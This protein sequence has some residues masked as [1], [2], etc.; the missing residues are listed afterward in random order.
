MSEPRGNRTRRPRRNQGGERALLTLV[1]LALFPVGA[2]AGSRAVWI[3]EPETYRMLEDRRFTRQV[4]EFLR[5]RSVD[6]VFLYADEFQGRN[7]I[8]QRPGLYRGLIRDLRRGGVAPHALLGSAYLRTQE[9]ILPEKREAALAMVRRVLE[10]NAA[11]ASEERFAGLQLDIEPHLLD[12]WDRDRDALLGL[13][14]ARSAE[15]T[16]MARESGRDFV[17]SAA[18]PFWLDGIEIDW[19]GRGARVSDHVQ[20]LYDMVVLMDYRDHALGPDG[21]IA[22]ARDEIAYAEAHG[23]RVMIGLETE[24]SEPAKTTFWEEGPR[25]LERELAITAEAFASS[26]ALDGFSVHH[27][28]TWME[29]WRVQRP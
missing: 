13:F 3:W 7:L 2:A 12:R 28:R 1:L 27:L 5:D 24:P 10:F 19:N 26:Q 15:W 23:K 9:Y 14:L 20:A 6:R 21:I 16:A 18:I 11:S 22:H 25:A 8:R 29:L 17:V 4:L